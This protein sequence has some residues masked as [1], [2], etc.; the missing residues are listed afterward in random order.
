M[1]TLM[2]LTESLN[3]EA[4]RLFGATVNNGVSFTLAGTYNVQKLANKDVR[5][6]AIKDVHFFDLNVQKK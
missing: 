2:S 1:G 5:E 3:V 6:I 4:T